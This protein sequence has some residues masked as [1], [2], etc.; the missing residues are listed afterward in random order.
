MSAFPQASLATQVGLLSGRAIKRITRNPA[1][2]VVREAFDTV[3]WTP[4]P[5]GTRQRAVDEDGVRGVWITG[6]RADDSAGV[7]LHLH[8]GGFIFGS[9]KTHRHFV[10][11]LSVATGRSA[12]LLDYRRAP[13]HPFPAAADDALAAY[14]WLLASGYRA[15]QIVVASKVLDSSGW[16]P[17]P[18]CSSRLGLDGA[19]R[20]AALALADDLRAQ[21]GGGQTAGDGTTRVSTD[22]ERASRSSVRQAPKAVHHHH[23]GKHRRAGSAA[24]AYVVRSGDTLSGIASRFHTSV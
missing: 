13:E 23:A 10:A 8:G 9:R 21:L 18:A 24:D 15:E 12:F 14:R 16:S 6:R 1:L 22:G 3:G 20:R 4:V 17:W 19:D 11:A 5:R 2:Q 7:L